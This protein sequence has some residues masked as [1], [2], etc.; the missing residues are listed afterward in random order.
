[1]TTLGLVFFHCLVL[2][3]GIYY[4]SAADTLTPTQSIR[5]GSTLVSSSKIFELGFF[6][7]GESKNQYLAI[8]YKKFPDIVVWIANR[9]NPVK[10]SHAIH[11]ISSTGNLVIFDGENNIFWSS[12]SSR[13]TKSPVF[14]QL[15]DSGNFVVRDNDTKSYLWE[16]F[17]FPSDTQLPGMKMGRNFKTGINR[18]LTA[19]KD[20]Y[21]PSPGDFTYRIDNIGLPQL[22]LRQGMKKRFRTGPWNGIRFSGVPLQNTTVLNYVFVDT[23]EELYINYAVKDNSLI[24]RFMLTE[25]GLLQRLVLYGNSGEWTV[26]YSVQND[27]CDDYAQCGPNGI[28]RINKRPICE[29]LTGFLP[30]LPHEWE[31]LNWTGGCARRT[32]L[33]CQ[34]GEGFV[35]LENVKLPDLLEFKFNK[36]L[37]LKECRAECFKNCSC[38]AYANSDISNGGSGCL[39]WFGNLID[40]REYI[41]GQSKQDIYIRMPASELSD[42]SWKSKNI[43]IIVVTSTI[44]GLLAFFLACWY[45][46][47]KKK[48]KKI[49]KQTHP[50]LLLLK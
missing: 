16:S 41:Q 43:V 20:V 30:R 39:M 17:D 22:F 10:D 35:K 36:N 6:S 47:L 28:C 7:P 11:T 32:P 15:L 26:M 31:V 12:N 49:G 18:F 13:A 45:R 24:S 37:N 9:E 29:C 21:D 40:I 19:W 14:A 33:D 2:F 34:K 3:S 5:N 4:S 44:S 42:S 1:M 8:W 48:R 46:I 50:K 23:T 27:L 38:T 25:S